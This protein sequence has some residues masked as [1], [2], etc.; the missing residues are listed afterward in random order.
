MANSRPLFYDQAVIYAGD[1]TQANGAGMLILGEVRDQVTVDIQLEVYHGMLDRTGAIAIA[2]TGHHNGANP[3]ANIPLIGNGLEQLAM[4]IQTA[5]IFEADDGEGGTTATDIL[6]YGI[7]PGS[8]DI[9]DYFT[10]ALVPRKEAME[11]GNGINSKNATWF[12]RAMCT[13]FEPFVYDQPD[14]DDY[15]GNYAHPVT[16]QAAY[17]DKDQADNTI[18]EPLRRGFRGPVSQAG[19]DWSLPVY[20]PSV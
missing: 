9:E 15:L 4:L 2:G 17:Y 10:L 3:I 1:P 16:I 20:D 11:E 19:L 13:S 12:P 5:S 7:A 6:A 14:S 18:P 8:I